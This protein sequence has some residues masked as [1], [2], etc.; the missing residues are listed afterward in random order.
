M[1]FSDSLKHIAPAL[2]D[3]QKEVKPVIK[4]GDNPHFRSKYV[5]LDALIEYVKP[6]LSKHGLV[7]VQ[8]GAPGAHG[9]VVQTTLIHA[10]SGEFVTSTFEL[11]LQKAD[12]Q[13]AGS[14][15][16]YGKR[17]GL[18]AILAISTDDD[19]DGNKASEF[20]RGSQTGTRMPSAPATSAR[21]PQPP[22]SAHAS[23]PKCHSDMWDNRTTKKNPKQP[24][25]KCKDKSCDGVIWPPKA[26]PDGGTSQNT[27]NVRDKLADS[28]SMPSVF[29]DEEDGL[30]SLPF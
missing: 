18:A 12:P 17:Y 20:G 29:Q 24:D 23:C 11:P 30:E 22:Q 2:L 15:I 21:V 6:I 14:A 5:T 8:G 9:L 26:G 28:L 4:D 19:D 10:I 3:V 16:T 27:A 1:Q 13:G 25:F 7:L